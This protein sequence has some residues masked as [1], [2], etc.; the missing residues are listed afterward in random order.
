MSTPTREAVVLTY[1]EAWNEADDA[2]R[3]GLLDLCWADDGTYLDPT[4][5]VSGRNALSQHIGTVLGR[6][7]GARVVLLSDVDVHHDVAR[8]LWRVEL[9]GGRLGDTSID[10]C[11]FGAD[12]RLTR[13]VGF[14]GEI[15]QRDQQPQEG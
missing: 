13:V 12:G 2:K 8:F 5:A 10:V 14:F 1:V 15:H 3:L 9:P 11:D 7:P 6:R 4:A